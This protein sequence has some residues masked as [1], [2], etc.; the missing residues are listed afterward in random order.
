M[1]A[2][3]PTLGSRLRHAAEKLYDLA[4]RADTP[5]SSIAVTEQLHE[6]I[7]IIAGDV[8]ASVR[9]RR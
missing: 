7:E 5:R 4:D 3:Q 2:P 9:G 6:E 8:R 1:A